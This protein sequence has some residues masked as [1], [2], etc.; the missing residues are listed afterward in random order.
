MDFGLATERRADP[1]TAKLTATGIILPT[2]EVLR[3]AQ[4]RGT[5]LDARRDI[6][7]VFLELESAHPD[8][9][10]EFELVPTTG[11]LRVMRGRMR[12]LGCR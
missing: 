7:Q 11:A 4:I 6:Q 5:Q 3:P 9:G 12:F 1:A 8:W 10:L 2:P